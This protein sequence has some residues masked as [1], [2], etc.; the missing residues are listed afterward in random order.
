MSQTMRPFSR[1]L[2]AAAC[3]EF[4]GHQEAFARLQL[5]ALNRQLGVLSGE[6]G[7]GK[8]RCYCAACSEAW[9]R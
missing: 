7:S 9:I 4:R 8:N 3:Y 2:D 5:A 1:E 6:V